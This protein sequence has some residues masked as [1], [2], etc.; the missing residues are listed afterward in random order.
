MLALTGKPG[1]KP[2]AAPHM[3]YSTLQRV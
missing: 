2:T 3:T 1:I